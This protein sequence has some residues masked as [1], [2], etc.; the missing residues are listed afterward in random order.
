MKYQ[1]HMWG[2]CLVSVLPVAVGQV[3]AESAEGLQQI[4]DRLVNTAREV[5]R[6]LRTVSDHESGVAAAGELKP[7]LEYMHQEMGRLSQQPVAA[8][9][10]ARTLERAMRDL[11]HITQVYMGVVQRLHEVNAYGAEELMQLFRFYKMSTPSSLMAERRDETPQERAYGEW[12][13]ALDDVLYLLRRVNDAESASRLMAELQSTVNR[14][15]RRASQVEGLQNEA[16]QLSVGRASLERF[17]RLRTELNRELERL[18]QAQQYGVDS[19]EP[20]LTACA[21]LVQG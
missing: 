4:C 14:A 1:H 3:V 13:D 17:M 15:E 6:Q 2:F 12:C 16:A 11:M 19:L 8:P 21:R 10:D 9:E 7:L 20:V 18:R 5:E